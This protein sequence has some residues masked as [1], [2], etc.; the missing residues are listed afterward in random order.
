MRH[1][2]NRYLLSGVLLLAAC[3]SLFS[4]LTHSYARPDGPFEMDGVDH[5]EKSNVG[6]AIMEVRNEAELPIAGAIVHHL[7]SRDH[8]WYD[9]KYCSPGRTPSWWPPNPPPVFLPEGAT[10]GEPSALAGRTDPWQLAHWFADTH[11]RQE[12]GF[13]QRV[14]GGATF[15][16]FSGMSEGGE[17]LVEGGG[18]VEVKSLRVEG[19]RL[20]LKLDLY[21]VPWGTKAR[22]W[23]PIVEVPISRRLPRGKYLLDVDFGIEVDGDG[24]EIQLNN[25][26][27]SLKAALLKKKHHAVLFSIT[28]N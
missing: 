28:D 25:D 17:F 8:V 1:R 5:S 4:A 13:M 19:N 6:S 12:K 11:E 22:A 10:V 7:K 21:S 20:L 15:C 9:K 27:L 24:A 2:V 16:V 18:N 3:W 23:F 14:K 26:L